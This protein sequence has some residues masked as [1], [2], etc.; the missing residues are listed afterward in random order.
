M[1]FL[2]KLTVD[3]NVKNHD[4]IIKENKGAL[5]S[6]IASMFG[7]AKGKVEE[8]IRRQVKIALQKTIKEHLMKNGV[9]ADVSVH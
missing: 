9:D 7:G 8:E 1:I 6:G 5:A 2:I 3:I 4:Q